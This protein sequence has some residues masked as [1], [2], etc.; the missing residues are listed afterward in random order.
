MKT[1]SQL[2]THYTTIESPVGKLILSGD[3]QSLTGVYIC[4]EK[5]AP[6]IHDDWIRTESAF[7]TAITQLNE[8]FSGIRF[9]FDLPIKPIG[10]EFQTRVWQRLCQIPYG[11]T[12]GYGELAKELGNPNAS[13]AVGMANGRNP[14]SIIVPCHRVIGANGSLTGYGGGLVAKKWLLE[15]E[16][17]H[18]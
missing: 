8:Y 11:K 16:A 1:K 3:G 2:Q 5:H 10:T 17:A 9:H 14:I 4:N 13:R 15:H 12:C 7:A 6:A 18:R